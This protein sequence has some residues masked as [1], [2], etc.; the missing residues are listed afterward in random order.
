MPL[1]K[2]LHFSFYLSILAVFAAAGCASYSEPGSVTRQSFRQGAGPTVVMLGGGV[3]GAAMFEP[4]AQALATEFD[5]IRI[6]TLNV[7][8]AER[9]GPMPD[10]YSISAEAEAV[11]RTLL[12]L[13]VVGPVDVVGSSLGAVVALRLAT[14]YPS[15]VKSL[16]L[17]EPP[18]FWVLPEEEF[19]RDSTLLQMRKLS[20]G[21]KPSATPSDDDLYRFRCILG[22]CPSAI[23]AAGDPARLEWDRSRKSMRGLAA[24]ATHHE[25][26][27]VI[28][29][30]PQPVL[31]LNGTNTVPFHRR[32]NELLSGLLPKYYIR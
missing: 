1:T 26:V 18:A 6:Q 8:Q 12:S 3:Y 19:Q 13:G 10:D 17:F 14:L 24:V 28:R 4:H 7:Q 23:P 21:M 2:S 16:V 5:V 27:E 31:L 20:S 30:L 11:H 9:G 29:Q 25:N 15:R 22:S 32:I